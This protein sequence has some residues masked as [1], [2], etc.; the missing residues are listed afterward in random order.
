MTPDI[1]NALFEAAASIFVWFNVMALRRD[2]VVK[3]VHWTPIAVF[4]V[5]GYWNM[6]YY[7]HLDQWWSFFAGIGVAVANTVWIL[8]LLKIRKE[9]HGS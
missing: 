2:R 9:R 7:P 4:A 5:W 6:Y 1:I 3:G 8:L